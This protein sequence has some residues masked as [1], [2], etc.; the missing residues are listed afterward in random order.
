MQLNFE[1]YF[2]LT[3]S[4]NKFANAL[5][6][7]ALAASLLGTPTSV[8]A[9][10]S[11]NSPK[12]TQQQTDEY[13]LDPNM[14]AKLWS[15]YYQTRND[16]VKTKRATEVANV[17][18]EVPVSAVRSIEIAANIF[19]GDMGV[20]KEVIKTLLYYT[21]EIESAY[22]HKKQLKGGPA[23]SYWQ[24]EPFTAIDVILN[25]RGL[26]G[27]KFKKQFP[28]YEQLFAMKVNDEAN[29]EKIAKMML[30]DQDLAAAFA[31]A[32]WIRHATKSSDPRWNIS[33]YQ[34]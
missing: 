16:P 9:T 21:G 33:N 14:I 5:K 2:Y 24:V 29:Q 18:F 13:V 6:T 17:R 3:E 12:T 32:T 11:N 31:A 22:L 27:P 4:P 10:P 28:Y 8:D 1:D 26:L 34:R 20:D 19:D 23:R 30:Q 15:K 7:G 25:A